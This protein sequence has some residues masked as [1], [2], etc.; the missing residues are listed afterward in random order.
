MIGLLWLPAAGCMAGSWWGWP[1]SSVLSLSVAAALVGTLVVVFVVFRRRSAGR[2]ELARI[3]ERIEG[4]AGSAAAAPA[5]ERASD[6]VVARVAAAAV[7]AERRLAGLVRSDRQLREAL[8]A[9]E[10]PLL[11][12]D[13]R[14]VVRLC[15]AAARTFFSSRG[16]PVEGVRLDDLFTQAEIVAQHNEALRGEPRQG[17]VKM[18][19]AEG[20][21]TIEIVTAPAPIGDDRRGAVLTLRDVTEVAQASQLKTDFVANA[22]HELRTPLASI[23]A[24]VETMEG[25]RDDPMMIER[26]ARMINGNVA[27]L[28]EMVSDL[29]DLSRLETP[30]A[31]V[32]IEPIRMSE[33]CDTLAETFAAVALER[34]LRFEFEIDP[35]V[36]IVQTDPKLLA[37][38]LKN[39]VENAMKF[40][41]ESTAVRIVADAVSTGGDSG[42][43]SGL[44]S[45]A[46]RET[47]SMRVS[48]IDRGVGIPFG[49]QQRIFERFF[50]VDPSRNGRSNR[51]GTGLGLAIVKHAVKRLGGTISVE[52]V[53]KEGTTM[54]VELPMRQ[55]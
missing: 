10:A 32:T 24:A 6:S 18:V 19:R 48:V 42:E 8:D 4:V 51:R 36:E 39:L 54:T 43:P 16:S 23:R 35:G 47:L 27:R 45:G 31:P 26:L 28:E 50:Q 33:V 37:L 52:S 2:S 25:A 46:G 40:A 29:L 14:G 49:H 9:T 30:E 41:Y 1:V 12:T 21:R 11:A 53:W 38:I 20:L 22:S 17:L 13:G 44:G 7:A 3:A 55:G 34:K 15:N 5:I